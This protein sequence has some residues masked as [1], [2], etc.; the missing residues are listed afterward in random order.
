MVKLPTV[1]R[2][3]SL[4]RKPGQP[5]PSAAASKTRESRLRGAFDHAP[6]GIALA[7]MHGTWLETNERFCELIGY[8]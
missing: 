7:S 6:V 8:T 2:V 5:L 3:I 1:D 4:V